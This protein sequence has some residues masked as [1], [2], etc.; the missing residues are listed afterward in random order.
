MSRAVV[1]GA[2]I[3]GLSA[4]RV[5]SERFDEVVV[6][7]RDELS[8]APAGRRGVPQGRHVHALLMAGVQRLASWFPGLDDDLIAAG[9]HV[10]DPG[11]DIRWY[12]AGGERLRAPSPLRRRLCS[13]PLLEAIVRRHVAALPNVILRTAAVGGLAASRDRS[14]VVGAVVSGDVL[15]ADIV[16]DASG[17]ASRASAW[18]E[19]LGYAPPRLCEV[20]IDMHYASRTFGR[21]EGQADFLMGFVLGSPPRPRHGVAFAI[22]GDRWM[23]TLAGYNT[24]H[25]PRDDAGWRAFAKSLE[26]PLIADL[27][28]QAE[29]LTEVV[30]HRLPSNRRHRIE[31]MRRA[32][33]GFVILGDAVASFNPVYGQGMSSAMLQAEALGVAL[34]RAGDTGARFVRDYNRR[35]GR[36]VAA[37]WQLCIRN[38]YAYPSTPGRRPFG[39]RA[40]QAYMRRVVARTHSD[41][42][43]LRRVV[44]VTQ[45]VRPI[46]DL[47]A[48]R[49]ARRV[50][51]SAKA[52]LNRAPHAAQGAR[53]SAVASPTSKVRV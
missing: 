50:V 40:R 15:E 19:S 46:R 52:K 31:T 53:P 28:A 34:D 44:E 47:Y 35:V 37:P 1:V 24:D 8:D 6:C 20:Q 18:L 25:A 39:T 45:L 32:P 51:F 12:Q 5:L 21:E 23:I 49:I 38:D 7:E 11:R 10:V 26:S 27:V 33:G 42:V 4:A 9:A 36:V 48:P 29:P 3:A 16:V 14:T 17:R 13:R 41:P 30:T 22:E 2:S 43:V